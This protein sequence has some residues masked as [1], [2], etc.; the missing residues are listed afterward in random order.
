MTQIRGITA[1]VGVATLVAYLIRLGWR[2]LGEIE[3]L[4]T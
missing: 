4:K 1:S 3:K 2:E